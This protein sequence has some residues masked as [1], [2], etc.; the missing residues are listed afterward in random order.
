MVLN[1]MT[2][3][4]SLCFLLSGCSGMLTD[5]FVGNTATERDTWH[6]KGMSPDSQLNDLSDC[7]VLSKEKIDTLEDSYSDR[8]NFYE[9]CLLDRGYK[10]YPRGL[11]GTKASRCRLGYGDGPAC[12]PQNFK[13]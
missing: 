1:N 4:L 6:K 9:K 3:V 12:K 10:F 11:D 5:L 7:Y 13:K 8:K 2:K